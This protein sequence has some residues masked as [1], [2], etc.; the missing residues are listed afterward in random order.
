MRFLESIIRA[1][2]ECVNCSGTGMKD[3]KMCVACRGDGGTHT[4]TI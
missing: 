1:W 4:E 2:V 3:G